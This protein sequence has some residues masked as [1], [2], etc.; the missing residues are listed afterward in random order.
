MSTRPF[1]SI[2]VSQQSRQQPSIDR[3]RQRGVP[4]EPIELYLAVPLLCTPGH[5]GRL[6][7]LNHLAFSL[8]GRFT[9]QGV[10][11]DLQD[12]FIELHRAA[13]LLCPPG[14]SDRSYSI[15]NLALSLRARFAQWGVSSD[16]DE[17]I[18]LYRAAL[19]FRPLGHSDR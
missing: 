10:P 18:E 16:I 11:S 8:R 4:S 13:L 6:Y 7:S 9:Q 17:S 19:L 1:S 14:H 3:F 12:E 15:N 5:S 2:M